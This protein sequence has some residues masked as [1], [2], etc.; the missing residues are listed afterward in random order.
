MSSVVSALKHAYANNICTE[1][2]SGGSSDG[3]QATT[4]LGINN[5]ALPANTLV[6]KQ[7]RNGKAAFAGALKAPVFDVWM[8]GRIV[9]YPKMKSTDKFDSIMKKLGANSVVGSGPSGGSASPRSTTTSTTD[10]AQALQVVGQGFTQFPPSDG[11]S[12]ASEAAVIKWNGIDTIAENVEVTSTL[13]DANGTVVDSE[14]DT[15]PV[16]YPG[17]TVALAHTPQVSGA[18]K[19]T[20]QADV[21][22]TDAFTDSP[23]TFSTSGITTDTSDGYSINT[24]GSVS[25]TSTKELQEVFVT[26]VYYDS[27]GNIIGGNLGVVNFIP[28]QGQTSFTAGGPG[29]LPNL[30]STQAFPYL[31]NTTLA[32]LG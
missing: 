9:A 5:C 21:T 11:Y 10:L 8:A 3:S 12:Y 2:T 17:E 18:V 27:A 23:P 16:I 6:V 7:Y 32:D 26:A 13:T 4:R 1:S 22:K 24:T 15:F 25:S 31:S 29:T 20:V 14:Q 28:A 30:A 19:L